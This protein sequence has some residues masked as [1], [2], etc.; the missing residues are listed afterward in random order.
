MVNFS[1]TQEISRFMGSVSFLW[2][3]EQPSS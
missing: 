3:S 2:C 1:N